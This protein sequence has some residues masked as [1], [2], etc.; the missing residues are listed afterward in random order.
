MH[1]SAEL[2]KAERLGIDFAVLGPINPTPTHPGVTPI[3]WEGF[4]R[5]ARDAAIPVFA[6]GGLGPADLERAWMHGAHGIAMV[7]GAWGR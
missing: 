1:T 6:I 2:R 4:E 5:I 3:G 7:R